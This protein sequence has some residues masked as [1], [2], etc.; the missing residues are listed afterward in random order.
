[1]SAILRSKDTASYQALSRE[2]RGVG[3][4]GRL[5]GAARIFLMIDEMKLRTEEHKTYGAHEK[6]HT[7]RPVRLIAAGKLT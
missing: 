5:E 2:M 1:M 6:R 7:E 3:E 4:N